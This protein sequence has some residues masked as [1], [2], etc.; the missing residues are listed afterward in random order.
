MT[1]EVMILAMNGVIMLFA[2]GLIYPAMRLTA[3][4]RMLGGDLVLTL[5]SLAA[6]GGLFAGSGVRFGLILF[7]TNWFWFAIITLI[8]TEAPLFLWFCRRHDIDLSG[9]EP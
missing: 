8:V 9:G 3:L 1:P 4:N 6:A 2:Y 5:L 7:E